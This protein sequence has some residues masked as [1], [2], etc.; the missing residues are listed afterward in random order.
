M[1]DRLFVPSESMGRIR[2]CGGASV[3]V[4]REERDA[5]RRSGMRFQSEVDNGEGRYLLRVDCHGGELYLR[6]GR[7]WSALCPSCE[8]LESEVRRAKRARSGP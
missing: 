1:M 8:R 6:D 5:M 4:G 2:E 7:Y 3:E